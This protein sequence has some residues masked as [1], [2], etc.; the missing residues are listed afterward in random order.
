MLD[1]AVR[2][3]LGNWYVDAIDEAGIA[4]IGEPDLDL[5]DLPGQGKPLE[6]SIEIG[7][8]PK[9]TLGEYK[10]IEVGRREPKV[11][12]AA[13]RREVE[14]LR[15][16][17]ATLETVERR[18]RE[19]DH[20]VVDYVGTLDGEPFEGGAGRDQLIELGAG[21]L[22]PGLRGA[23]GRPLGGRRRDRQ[24]HVPR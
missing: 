15:D 23:A 17:V 1:E 4:P 11:D 22:I 16:R 19:G 3:S 9:A 20:L 2:E 8:R 24:G 6:F 21:R 7:V 10:G 12:D 5:A 13:A 14:Q 18:R